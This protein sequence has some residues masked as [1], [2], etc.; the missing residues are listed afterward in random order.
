MSPAVFEPTISAS[1][2]PQTHALDRAATGIG[3]FCLYTAEII[4]Y[5]LF[6]FC[7]CTT[8]TQQQKKNYCFVEKILQGHKPTLQNP[9]AQVRPIY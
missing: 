3:F 9:S 4:M 7:I 2:R 1:E 5:T 6:L 8:L